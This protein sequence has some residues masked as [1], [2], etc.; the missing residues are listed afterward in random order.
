M[1]TNINFNGQVYAVPALGDDGWGTAVSNYLIAIAT[2]TFQRTGGSFTL[3]GEPDF[4]NAFGLK[5]LYLKSKA[6][7]PSGTGA[8]RL[9]NTEAVSWRNAANNADL[10]ACEYPF[11]SNSSGKCCKCSDRS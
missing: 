1:S 10:A 8:L 3:S 9:G 11:R 7:N 2:G 6:A 5:A 4:G